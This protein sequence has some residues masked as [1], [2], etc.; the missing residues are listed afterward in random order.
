MCDLKNEVAIISGWLF[1]RKREP[2]ASFLSFSV[3]QMNT[4]IPFHLCTHDE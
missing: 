2:Y 4:A 3:K 1:M